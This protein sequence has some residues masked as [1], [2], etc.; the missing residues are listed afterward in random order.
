MDR[1]SPS[2][3]RPGLMRKVKDGKW[4]RVRDHNRIVDDLIARLKKAAEINRGDASTNEEE[5]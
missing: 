4:M 3:Y 2:Q 1:F 5:S